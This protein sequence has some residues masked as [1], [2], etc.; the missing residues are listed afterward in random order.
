MQFEKVLSLF[1]TKIV[2]LFY[3]LIL[4][5]DNMK[6]WTKLGGF[7]RP[8]DI[9]GLQIVSS[10]PHSWLFVSVFSQWWLVVEAPCTSRSSTMRAINV[11]FYM[12]TSHRVS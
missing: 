5:I 12:V 4:I 2:Y 7:G 11:Y 8:L 6:H 9:R 1:I 10:S 3:I